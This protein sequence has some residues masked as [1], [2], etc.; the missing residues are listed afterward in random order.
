[1]RMQ[2]DD[3]CRHT[4]Q[5]SPINSFCFWA[6]HVL[7]TSS[8]YKVARYFTFDAPEGGPLSLGGVPAGTRPNSRAK[9]ITTVDRKSVETIDARGQSKLNRI[10]LTKFIP[11]LGQSLANLIN[12]IILTVKATYPQTT[13][14]RKAGSETQL[15]VDEAILDYLIYTAVKAQLQ[16]DYNPIIIANHLEMVDCKDK[17]L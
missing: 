13:M 12:V 4:P 14:E 2:P 7:N 6:R 17:H 8:K 15:T 9:T 1:M 10:I 5:A 16:E 11:A 3:A